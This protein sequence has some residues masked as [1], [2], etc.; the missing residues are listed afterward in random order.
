[1]SL[2]WKSSCW[3]MVE[4]SSRSM[5]ARGVV[6]GPNIQQTVSVAGG[7]QGAQ[8]WQGHWQELGAYPV[9]FL[10]GE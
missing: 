1:M 3:S 9:R 5:L 6:S 10:T 7:T 2:D 4:N 8:D